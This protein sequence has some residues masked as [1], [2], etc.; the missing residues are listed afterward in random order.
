MDSS[1]TVHA[2]VLTAFVA[3]GLVLVLA[4]KATIMMLNLRQTSAAGS[5][6]D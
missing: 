6:C 3:A 1:P 2:Y 5:R 4:Q